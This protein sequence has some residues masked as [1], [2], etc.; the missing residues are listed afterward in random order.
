MI[1]YTAKFFACANVLIAA[2]VWCCAGKSLAAPA[3]VGLPTEKGL[4]LKQQCGFVNKYVSQVTAHAVRVEID[5]HDFCLLSFAP[6][7]KVYVI[8]PKTKE[9]AVVSHHDWCYK[10]QIHGLS[11]TAALKEPLG[12]TRST[13]EGLPTVTYRYGPT[14]AFGPL[15]KMTSDLN[16]EKKGTLPNHAEV[17]CLDYPGSDKTGPIMGRFRGLPPVRGLVLKAYR[18]EKNGTDSGVIETSDIN[19]KVKIAGTV[20]AVPVSYKIVDFNPR[21]VQTSAA[22]EN[23]R[24]LLEDFMGK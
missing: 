3:A 8:R 23:S 1:G 9:M 15:L 13:Q 4:I 22:S 16:F 5:N 21:M 10:Y 17:V 12:V 2:T 18:R 6:E 11:W 7:W 19:A 20:F 24:A 14:E